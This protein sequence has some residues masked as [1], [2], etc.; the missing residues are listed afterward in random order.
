MD[1]CKCIY[2]V[3]SLF[4]FFEIYFIKLQFSNIFCLLQ[5]RLEFIQRKDQML[6]YFLKIKVKFLQNFV[7]ESWSI[8]ESSRYKVEV[9]VDGVG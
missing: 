7:K 1:S 8:R 6:C 2:C 4:Y 3:V 9:R 5:L